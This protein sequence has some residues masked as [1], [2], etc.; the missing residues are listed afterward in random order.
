MPDTILIIEDDADILGSLE[1]LFIHEGYQV[2]TAADGKD[3]LQKLTSGSTLPHLILA[4]FVMPRMDGAEFRRRQL[5][6]ARLASIPVIFASASVLRTS[7]FENCIAL[8]KPFETQELL[9]TV[10]SAL[11]RSS[12]LHEQ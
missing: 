4:D 7:E 5:E 8:K 3:A 2:M 9:N 1:E 12:V 10:S 11:C 6:D